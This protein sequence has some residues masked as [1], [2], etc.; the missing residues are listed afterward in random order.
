MRTNISGNIINNNIRT[1]INE[2]THFFIKK[3]TSH[4]LFSKGLRKGWCWLYVRGGL[5]TGTDCHIFTQSS[6]DHSSTSFSSWLGCSTV[7]H[8]GPKPSVCRWLSIRHL[9][10]NRLQ[11]RLELEPTGTDWLKPS[12]A[13][14]Y[15][16]VWHPPASCGRTHLHRIQPCPQVKVIFRY[17]RPY[18]PVS[19]FFSL[20]TN[21]QPLIDGSVEGQ[22]VTCSWVGKLLHIRHFY[23]A[24][25]VSRIY[26]FPLCLFVHFCHHRWL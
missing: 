11:L 2:Q 21:V 19:L 14:G 15:I 26:Y 3:Y 24:S 1:S 6:S 8:W 5:E 16:I 12:V 20:F 22:Y 9:V 23:L 4:T 17:L 25:H 10:P 18:A 7:G 13:P